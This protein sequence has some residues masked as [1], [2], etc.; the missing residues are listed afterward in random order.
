MKDLKDLFKHQLT[1]LYNGE[2]QMIDALPKMIKNADQEELKDALEK[3]LE[4]TKNQKL[5]LEEICENLDI[6]LKEKTSDSMKSLIKQADSGM[7]DSQNKEVKHAGMIADA[8]K[9]E[10]HEIA[11]YGTAVC[12]AK[13][14]GHADIAEKLQTSLDE[15]HNAND[16]LNQLAEQRI[17]RKAE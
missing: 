16:T 10:H 6:E 2:I 15:E 13:E 1:E 9:I 11:G 12:Y 7:K 14:L 3:H 17:N 8:Q 5:R 4:E